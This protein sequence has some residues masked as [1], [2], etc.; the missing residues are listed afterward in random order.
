MEA[1]GAEIA[2]GR[3]AEALTAARAAMVERER[4][5]DHAGFSL[6]R[7]HAGPGHL[8]RPHQR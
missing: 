5:R 4:E 6:E 2:A 1:M 7:V 3:L 8:A